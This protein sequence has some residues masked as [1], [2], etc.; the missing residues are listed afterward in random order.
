M[1]ELGGSVG[2]HKYMY[3]LHLS[4]KSTDKSHG[5]SLATE[6]TRQEMNHFVQGV[7]EYFACR[8][9]MIIVPFHPATHAQMQIWTGV[10]YN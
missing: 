6:A 7:Q 3:I 8:R 5:Y 2:F 4:F 1:Y 10:V 9:A